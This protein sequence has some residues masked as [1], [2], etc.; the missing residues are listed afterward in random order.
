M[1]LIDIDYFRQMPLGQKALDQLPAEVIQEYIQTASD[2]V[3]DYLDHKIQLH[4]V[5]ERIVGKREFTLILDEYP[6]VALLDVSYDGY[7]GDVGTHATSDF[8]IHSEAGV[9]EWINKNYN[10]RGDRIYTVQYT[11]GYATVPTPIKLATALQTVQ[12]TR[13]MYGGVSEEPTGVPFADETI[14]SL[15]ERYRRKR[16]S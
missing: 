3:E 14:V 1:A 5:T 12:L 4:T 9:I 13:P 15:L 10:F 7:S 8:L 16:L 6:I 2:Y 11:A